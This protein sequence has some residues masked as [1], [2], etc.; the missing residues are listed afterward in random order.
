MKN[1][2]GVTD[3]VMMLLFLAKS[4][5]VRCVHNII[6]DMTLSTEKQRRHM[7][8]HCLAK[9]YFAEIQRTVS[10]VIIH[11]CMYVLGI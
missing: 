8:N 2:T 10:K 6:Y 5:D 11:T 7:I 4:F 9:P 3:V 1:Y